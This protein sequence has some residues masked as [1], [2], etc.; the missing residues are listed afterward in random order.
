MNWYARATAEWAAKEKAIEAAA[1]QKYAEELATAKRQAK[2][3]QEKFDKLAVDHLTEKA[4]NEKAIERHVAAAL[5][6]TERLSVLT[7]GASCS[8]P[9]EAKGEGTGPGAGTSD[10]ARTDL[11][12]STT[13][14]L[15]RIA[16]D[17]GQLVRDYN[18]VV[19]RYGV[20]RETCN[21]D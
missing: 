11:L 8:V 4:K 18:S 1:D 7:A 19:E 3:L 5:A 15:F 2:D 14:T 12:P 17:Y 21:A 13:A 9:G 10:E 6:N 16:G 20:I